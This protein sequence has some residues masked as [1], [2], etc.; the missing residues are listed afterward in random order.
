MTPREV[1][2]YRALRATIRE[3]GSLR[4]IV[5]IGIL[6]AWAAA[7]IATAA[8]AALPV[9]TLL[10]LFLLASG[11]EAIFA[12]HTGVERVGRYLQVFYDEPGA[13]EWERTTMAYGRAYPAGGPDA[14]F[15]VQFYLATVLNF[16]P[17]LIAEPVALELGVVGA[18]HV[19]F[20]VRIAHAHRMA[21][22]QRAADLERFQKIKIGD[23]PGGPSATNR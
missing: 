8:L 9:A 11:F 19:F 14:L 21:G 16:I 6:V 15:S 23:Q 3:R 22:R 10:P 13:R 4:F 7:T 18:F 12:L 20:M 2:E 17:V 5:F 1:E